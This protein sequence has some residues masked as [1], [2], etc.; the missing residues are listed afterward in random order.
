MSVLVCNIASLKGT[1][2][3]WLVPNNAL[4]SRMCGWKEKHI[5]IE[6]RQKGVSA[7]REQET[8]QQYNDKEH[9]SIN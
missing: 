3:T 9:M 4:S 1:R 8:L 7:E 5:K 2:S 6:K